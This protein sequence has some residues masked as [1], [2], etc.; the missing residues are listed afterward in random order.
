MSRATVA[1]IR[2][3][4]GPDVKALD[5]HDLLRLVRGDVEPATPQYIK[6]ELVRMAS[7]EAQR[8]GVEFPF[9]TACFTV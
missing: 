4:Y 6:R 1:Q 5:T 8:R 9:F 7:T 3:R 2:K